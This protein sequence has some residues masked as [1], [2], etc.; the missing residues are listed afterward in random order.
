VVSILPHFQSVRYFYARGN[1]QYT[2]TTYLEHPHEKS[3]LIY[4][5]NVI[6]ERELEYVF[7]EESHKEFSD[8]ALVIRR[9]AHVKREI[10]YDLDTMPSLGS[11]TPEMAIDI[12]KNRV[13]DWDAYNNEK[14]LIISGATTMSGHIFYHIKHDIY[15]GIAWAVNADG[16]NMLF[17]IGDVDGI[18][19]LLSD[20]NEIIIKPK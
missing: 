14:K 3:P 13:N 17:D 8:A 5:G 15:S 6:I 16:G 20:G 4:T 10:E 7:D 11:V 9:K 18:W 12:V 19:N 1:G 2:V